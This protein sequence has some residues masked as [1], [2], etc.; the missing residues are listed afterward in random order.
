MQPP[1]HKNKT[2]KQQQQKKQNTV[3]LEVESKDKYAVFSLI[4]SK[5]I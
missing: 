5:K 4:V 3:Y 1:P 2:D